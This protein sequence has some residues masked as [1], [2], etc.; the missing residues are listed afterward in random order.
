MTSLQN[1][2][3]NFFNFK[4]YLFLFISFKDLFYVYGCLPECLHMY[5]VCVPGALEGQK[6]VL[7]PLELELYG[8]VPHVTPGNG[9]WVLCGIS[10]GS[11]PMSHPSS[12]T[13]FDF[14][15]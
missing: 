3:G 8:C 4:F 9:I 11:W 1:V 12:S 15:I 6:K 7:E 10:H 5:H 2:N 13:S 14:L